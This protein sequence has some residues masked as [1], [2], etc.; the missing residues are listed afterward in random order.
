[1]VCLSCTATGERVCLA[2]EGFGNRHCFLEN[3]ADKNIPPDLSQ[4]VFVIEQALSV[5][6]LQEL[7]TAA[8]SESGKGTGSGHRT[9]LYGN[10]ILLRHQNSDMYL[11]CLSTCSSNDKLSFDVG[12]QDHSQGEACWWTV[13]P[14]SKQRSEGEKVR[15]GDDLILV[16]V[17]TERY[18]HTTKENDQSIVNASFHVTHWSVQPYG[19]GISRMKYVGYVFGGDVLRFFH[20]GDECLTIPSTWSEEPG[21]NMVV[22]EGGSVM[23]QARSLWRLE[24]ARTK[25]SGGFI[26]WYHPMRIRHITTGRYLGVNENNE[27]YLVSRDEATTSLSTFCLRQEKD[28]QKVVLEDKDLEVIGSP[29]IKYGDSTV[30][31]QHSESGLWVSYKS[32]ET[33]KKGVGKVE[34][35]QAILHEEGKMDDGLDF[36]RSQEEESRT[37]RVIRK[38]SSLFTKFIKSLEELQMNR[39]TS[40]FFVNVNLAEI[41]MCLEDLINYFVQPSDDMEHEEKQNKL[42]ALRNRQDLFQEEGILNLILEAIDKINVITSQGFLVA[43]AGECG[44]NWEAISS[45]LYQL[46]AAIIKGN[47]TNCK[48]F[49]NSN[50][51]NWLFSRLGSQ[52]SGEG[53]G[54]L[55]VLHCVLIDSPEALNMMRDEHIK[56]IISLLEKHGRDP[57]VLDV[58]CSLCV[59]NGV[60]VRSSQN[61]ICDFLLPG[62]NLLLQT[63]LVDHVASVRPNIFVGRVEGSAV[64][65]KWYF[66]VTLD[67]I[68]QTTHMKPHLRIGWANT[69]GYVPYPGGGEKWGGNGVGDDLYSFGFDGANLW[70]GGRKTEVVHGATEPYIKKG[71]IIGVALDLTVPV[72]N[73]TFN[74]VHVK[75][76]FRNFNLDGMFFPVISCSSK[77]SCRFLLGGDH[78]RL[79]FVPPEEF[80]PLVECLMPQQVL[81]ID[82]CFY[83]GN[84]NKSVLAGPW[85][86]EGDT[87][88]VPNPVDTSTVTLPGYIEN[89]RDKLAENI[90]EMWAMNKIEAGW[91]YGDRRDDVRKIH[92][93]LTQFEKLPPAEKRYDSQLAIQTLK[94]ILA[95]GYYITM[96]KPPAR[97]KQVRLPNEPFMQPNGYKP[98]PLDLS[99][100]S[101]TPKMEE[102][103]DQL[104]ENTHNLW[105]KERI[106]QGWTYGLNEDP[107]LLRSPHL[108]PY[109]KV[110]EAIKKAN[111][112]TA[113]E[114]VRTLLVY[115]YNLD[116]PTGEQQDA[117]LAE[118][119]RLKE[120]GFRT[121]RVEKH[122][123]VSSGKWYFEFEILTAG[124][125]RVGWARADCP[126]GNKI[127]SDEYTW[128]F[129]GFNEEKVY[130]GTGESFGKQ[131][132]VGDVVGVFLDLL[133]RTISFS[134]NGELLMDALGGE[135]S[136]ADVQGDS[137]VPACT[138]GVGQKARLVYGQ[139]VNTL[140]YFSNCGLQEGYEPFCV[141]MNRPVTYW[142]TKDQ[143]IFENTDERPDSMIDVT[144]IPA[145]SDSPPCMKI[146]HNMFETME[147]ANWEFLRLSLPVICQSNLIDEEEKMRRWQEIKMRQRRLLA[148]QEQT[149]PAAHIEQIMKSGFSM[150]DIKGLQRGYSEDAVEADEMLLKPEIGQKSRRPS[151]PPRKGSLSRYDDNTLS[152]MDALSQD[153]NRSTSELDLNK[154]NGDAKDK[155]SR[156][157]SPFRFFS[158]KKDHSGDRLGKKG[159]TP[160]PMMNGDVEHLVPPQV[161]ISN[162][163]LRT[164]QSPTGDRTMQKQMSIIQTGG[165]EQAGNELYDAE[166]LKLM[167]EYFYGVRIFPG[168]DPT[169]TYVGWVTTQYH[170]FSNEFNQSKVRKASV[171]ITDDY[172]NILEQ[173]DRQSCYMVRA[174]ELYNEVSSDASGKGASQGMFIGC[175]VDTATGYISF[176]CEGKETSHKYKMEP[177]TKLFPAI[178]ME[179][180]SKEILQIE[181]GRTSTTLPLSAAVLM[182][183]ERHVNPQF[184]PR[185][186]VQC[187]KPN[188]WARVP[189]QS[190]QVHAL[191]LSDI[192]GWSMLCEDPISML[193]VHIPEEDRCIDVLELIEME[194][195][196]SFHAHTLTLYSA[197]CYQSNYRAAHILCTHVDERQLLYAIK[198]EYMSGPLRKGFY[199]LLISLHLESHATTMEVS[200]NEYIIPLGQELKDLYKNPEMCHSLR[201][202][203][204]ESVR[205]KM[206][207]TDISEQ[208]ENIRDLYSP[209]FPLDVVRD[210]VMQALDEA[211]QVNQVH[212]RDPIG[213]SNENLF[214]PLLKLVDRLL[215]VEVLRDEDL[216]K[217]LIMIDPE[218]WDESFDKEGKDEHRK[219]L[220]Q[221]KM[222]EGAKLQMCY[223]L[224]HV[225]DIQLRHRVESIIAF[226]SD[227]VGELQSDQLRRYTEIKQSD[228]PSAIAAKKTREFRCPPREQM[229]A[230]L[231]FKNLEEDD[232]ENC[233]CGVELREKLNNF[234][235]QLMSQVSLSALQEATD[236]TEEE[237]QSEKPT[238]LK[239]MFKFIHAVKELEEEPKAIEEPPKKSPEEI[240]RKVLIRTIVRWAE[241][242]QIETPKLVREMFSLLVRQY[243]SVGELIRALGKTYV[244]NTKT[245]GD[246]AL[247]W[248]GL[249]QIRSL[250][251]VQMSQEE[252]G[253]VRERLWKLVNNHT[254]F[255]HPDL[256][257]VL[258]IHENVMAIMMNTLGR[259]AQAQSDVPQTT[260]QGEV[261]VKE[262]DT[263]HEMVVACC[264]F[265]C[266]FCRTSRQNQKAMFDHLA[267]LLENS[268]IL[269]S[270][271]SL[272]GSTPLDVA[273]SSVMENT[274]LALA[275]R[276]HYLEKIAVY[277]SRCGL[278]SNSDLVE[279][280]YPDLGWDPVEGERYLDF[281][282]FCVWVNG[283]SVEENANLVIRL[284]I[285]RPECLGPALRGE[286]E[287]LLRAIVD[288][289]QMSER[290]A[291]RRK[292][293]DEAE[294]T[295]TIMDFQHPLPES[296]EDEDYIDTGAAILA[297]YCTLVDLLG[298]CAPDSTVIALGKNESMRARAILRSLVPLEDLQGV[299]ALRFTLQQP[300]A[301]EDRPKSDMPSGLIPG[302]KQSVVMFLERVYGIESQELF[303]KLLEEAFLPDLR[304]ATMLDRSDGSESEMALAMN[305]Y[306]GNSVLPLLIKHAKFYSEAD[307]YASLLDATLHTV[308]RLSKNRMLT[309]GQ[310]ESVSDFLVALTSQMQPSM[311]LKLLRKLTV[312]VSNLSEYTTVAL[313]LLTLHYDRCA[314]YYGASSGQQS[315]FGASSDE[316]K[317]LTMVLFSNIFDSLSKMDYDPD[318][319][320][321]ALPCLTAIGCALPPDYSLSKNFDD[322]I[323]EQ[324]GPGEGGSYTPQP[325]NTS[326]IVLNNDLNQIVQKFSEHYHDAWASRKLE[327]GWTYGESWSDTNKTHP[328]LKPYSTLNDYEKERYKEPVRESLKALM[329]IGWHVEHAEVDIQSNNRASMRR[330]S[331]PN[332]GD[333]SSPFSYHPHP[334][335][336]TNLTLNKEM[337]NMAERLAE[338]AHDIWAKKKKEELTTCGGAVHPQLVPYDLLTDKE[339]RKDRERSQEFL[340]YLQYQGFKLHRPTKGG[341]ET[342][343][344]AAQ[345]AVENRFAYSLLEKLIQYTDKAAINMKLLKPSSTF[346]RRSSFKP[347]S[348]DIK[349]FSKVVLPLIEKYFNSHKGYFIA[350]ATASNNV[351]AASL[352][353]KE[354]VASLFCKL[355][356]LLRIRLASFGADVRITVRCLQ[357]L[358]KSVDAKSLVKNCP[359]FIRTSMLT[360]FN[361]TADDLNVT[362][363]NLQEGKYSHLRGTHLKTCTSLGYIY[364]VV[365]PVLTSLFD[366]L[367]ACE[368]G[369]DLLLDEIQVAAYKI[370]GSLYTL[371]VDPSLHHERKY[372][373]TEIDRHRPALG[374][375]LGAFSS[376]FPVA[377]LEPHLN[378]HNQFSLLNRIADHSLEAQDVMAKMEQS[379][380]NLDAILSEVETFV[381]S[382]KTHN[383]VPHIIDVILPLLCSYLPFWWSQGPDNVSPQ[384]GNHVT[385]VTAEHMNQLLK[386][387]LKLIKKNIGN[388]NAPWMT[389]IAAYTQQIIINSSEELLKDPFLP[390]AERVRKR[391][392]NMFH[393]EESL[394]GFIKSASDDTSQVEAQIQEDWQLL[395]RDIYA[396]YPLLIKY[397]DLQ[398]NHWLRNN[399]AEAEDLYKHV[400]EIF[401][402]W[403]KSQYFL[404]EEQNFIS[405]NEI[406]NMVLIMPTATRRTAVASEGAP[407]SGSKK[408]KKKHRDKKR[409][410]DKELQASLMVA[411]LKRLLPVGLNLFAGREQELVQHCKDRYLKKLPEPEIV[412]FAKI[413]LTL[414]DKIDPADEMSW[415]HYLYSKL[416]SK[417]DAVVEVKDKE[418]QVEEL[419]ERIVAMAKVLFGLHMIDHPQQQGKAVYRSVVSTQRKRAVLSCF[420]QA[421]L[422]SLPRYNACPCHRCS[423]FV[424]YIALTR[425][426]CLLTLHTINTMIRT[427]ANFQKEEG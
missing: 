104:A 137:F 180:T 270:R 12:L 55:D 293:M 295:M 105:A 52:A 259:R 149:A 329:A 40:L 400:A 80:S 280:G 267:F 172:D 89:I 411:C 343:Q 414:P 50:R 268:N 193:A 288:A 59:G 62:K 176:T 260:E 298:R 402:M 406:D 308:Y 71:D 190:L 32:F 277:L 401:N 220:L 395:V 215:L 174:D 309:K 2:A 301:G 69:T 235:A 170:Y 20:G 346:S 124:P 393:K 207:M 356:N 143:P 199:D 139:D 110:D 218:T 273:Y 371:G 415:Q 255:Q 9:L 408:K 82:P 423:V 242:S 162:A 229:N 29:I 136:F 132:Q 165:V 179:A 3:I 335:D 114:T 266:Y 354:M 409:D 99:A 380:P 160:E 169:H 79:K 183:S 73:F 236:I 391:T 157:K 53:T 394:R 203:Q 96:D 425:S 194:R 92:P 66:E 177:E 383:D 299:L 379:M 65:Q 74:G 271:P 360:F 272:R 243:D 334:V 252:E 45:Y 357:V 166:C 138:L 26:N 359:E 245:R 184:P 211:V 86:V 420:R 320:G 292:L 294:G 21:Q 206:K 234:H 297:F 396:F 278:Q 140:Q 100:V 120:Q 142:Y 191:K 365:M 81:S 418:K 369:S 147:K 239:K 102:L 70:S 68:E 154:F 246:A 115:G 83:F 37:A 262:K 23:S 348:R 98:A 381:E 373:K 389:R 290:I 87:A 202:L 61:N 134:L 205:P 22:Y 274:E 34:E 282:R 77:L 300:A 327:N 422:H 155:K 17:A 427:K 24:L 424:S 258:R 185:L 275:L 241:E 189:N 355:A 376:T 209:S 315:M 247:M 216:Q 91:M 153:K 42:K 419:V 340:K 159:K 426:A 168:Q 121:Y 57:K 208:V 78:G 95:L 312:D 249:S 167:N 254:F 63:Q 281:L 364:S 324:G 289:N 125:M 25:W 233:P 412:D 135:T 331:K 338:N 46:L 367:A 192:R 392:E 363:T 362:I 413:Q 85:L 60:A 44:Q 39:R 339:K 6:A 257:R 30:I 217:L 256:I 283:E 103:V 372:L 133:D 342:E 128:A 72:I 240:F 8:G 328:R 175:F 43:L 111:R 352:K 374:N 58:L 4:C 403:S 48:E 75:G 375:C 306:M 197:L 397:V 116:P 198:S 325:I 201:S 200:K 385:M 107:D 344:A 276:E 141:N 387:V 54:M 287:G 263:S 264:R 64:Y 250:L 148:D 94:T 318:L 161:R 150:S 7:V 361:N 251:P 311:L 237:V 253:L 221:M 47:H 112:D 129:D 244:T 131:W 164:L 269:L 214:L 10:A 225:C 227:F 171:A 5:R 90:H 332:Q 145:G 377:F 326:S 1:M 313:R 314:K 316:E 18:L 123:A 368:Y 330:Q 119:N 345:A 336:M 182:N 333:G 232:T 382:D 248:V 186:K 228:L 27:L 156:G 152:P 84:L 113:S 76:S 366:H 97:I 337:Q 219:G 106:Q 19:T 213:G 126:P 370:L 14:A 67:H 279:K 347:C 117:L 173:I 108:V 286:G 358:V 122:Y 291:D 163:D 265:L 323:Y 127:G 407:Q 88:F 178:F 405:A 196:L 230:I 195:L 307:N 118:A 284:L 181:L 302:H 304:C 386:S 56:V 388:E 36:S 210:F 146:S 417:K 398:R 322:E 144:R 188:Q 35:K 151:R 28:D 130:C 351:G 158:R 416:G 353:E 187:L 378:K 11:A 222:A 296:D 231:G 212:N 16:S 303:F 101:L 49:A 93:C 317:R 410:K 421:S 350:V 38:C 384:G 109:A 319:F 310:R 261:P 238:V 390:L 13:H 285:R 33:K 349:F 223:V 404:K 31:M 41:V 305:R 321:K 341:G 51:L 399:I 15:V 204:M 226:S 224:H